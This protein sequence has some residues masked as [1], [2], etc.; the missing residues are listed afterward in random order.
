MWFEWSFQQPS[1]W[2][3]LSLS[4]LITSIAIAIIIILE[5]RS[6]FKT[7]AWV[8]VLVLIPLIGLIFYLFFGQEYRKKKLFSRRGLKA[9]GRYRSITSRQLRTIQKSEYQLPPQIGHFK[10]IISLLLNNSN[11]IVTTGNQLTILNNGKKTMEA[12]F[13]ALS[14]ARHHIHLEYYII[15]DDQTG[16]RLKEILLERRKAGVE[17][18]IIIDDVGSWGLG[19]KYIRELKQA[20]IDIYPFME[21]R[22]PRLTGKVNYRNHRKIVIVDGQIGFTGGVNIADRYIYG[23][24]KLGPWRDTHLQIEGDAVA[25]LQVVFAAD[26]FFVK[27]ENL[28]GQAYFRTFREYSG[29]PVQI[30]ASGPDSD[31]DSISQAF[32]SAVASARKE[33]FITT[34]YL[35]PTPSILTALKTAA[36][37]GIDVRIVMPEIPD[38][39]L[40]K[41]VSLSYVEELLE[42]GVRIFLY[43]KGFMHSKVLLVDGNFATVGTTNLDFRSLET[44]FEINAFVYD[45]Q[46]TRRM[47]AFLKLDIRNSREILLNEWRRRPWY[48][49][50]MES[51]AYLISPLF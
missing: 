18:R 24:K 41:W 31:W 47:S 4:F 8:L 44:N 51:F 13:N 2:G 40:P 1:V 45:E 16:N 20:G 36:L 25:C 35:M 50:S 29:V 33:V 17:V 49:K 38:A 19:R 15:E 9:L 3:I 12:V 22:F 46:F 5:K 27:G 43:Q 6:P 7:A 14:Q 37:G 10:K 39:L 34:P 21:V 28:T 23:T 48:K 32:F 11:A 30:S 26:W 42:A